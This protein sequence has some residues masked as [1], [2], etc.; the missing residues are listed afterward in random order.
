MEEN[1]N[2]KKIV[3]T[4]LVALYALTNLQA[5]SNSALEAKLTALET[6]LKDIKSTIKRNK[7]TIN[8]VKAHD[9]HDN[10]KWSVDFRT[11]LDNINYDMAD[12]SS[13]D[14]SALMAIRLY[15]NMA[16]AADEH[17]IFKAQ[18]AMNKTFGTDFGMPQRSMGLGSMFDWT[19]NESLSDNSLKIKEAYWLYL[20]DNL[21][22]TDL[23]WTLSIGRR[24]SV[25]GFLASLRED[26]DARSPVGHHIDLE[27]DGLSAM[28]K[29]ENL[30]GISGMSF[31]LCVGRGATDAIPMFD[32]NGEPAYADGI[33]EALDDINMMYGIFVP[34][35]D[36]QYKVMTGWYMATNLPGMDNPM[37]PNARQGFHQYGNMQG[38]AA[39]LLIDGLTE[40]GYFADAKL[41]AS[42][43]WSQTSPDEGSSMLGSTDDESGT[44]YWIGAN[45]PI[46]DDSILGLEFNHGSKYWRSLTYGEDTMIGSKLAARGDA[47]EGYFNYKI[48]KA[49]SAQLRYTYIDYDYTGSNGFFGNYSGTPL[50]ISDIKAGKY[51]DQMKSYA[52][53]SSQDLRFYIR[54]RF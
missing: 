51:G 26:D 15:L 41:F 39:S 29:L 53:E 6:E 11:G 3:A 16:Y 4:S 44:S 19:S 37:D 1:S 28:V 20:G 10:I 18:I 7:K 42:F 50:K 27:F 47:Y 30:T 21:F 22:G 5:A 13:K 17:N 25:G 35:D 24:P 12:G 33:G 14:N 34:Y 54:Y 46:T 38:A 40:D 45:L 43:A 8:K 2:M 9:A 32:M 49:L 23:P 31:K 52:V 36:G 48:N